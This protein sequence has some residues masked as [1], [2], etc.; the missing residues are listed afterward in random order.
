MT[1]TQARSE[2]V[3]K[4]KSLISVADL[5]ELEFIHHWLLQLQFTEEDRAVY[6][7]EN[8]DIIL[9]PDL[10]FLKN[11]KCVDRYIYLE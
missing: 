9:G 5:A 7:G 11:S 3:S 6:L 10:I 1:W 4:G 2:C 8:A